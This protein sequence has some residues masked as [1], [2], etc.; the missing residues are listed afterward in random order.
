MC[1]PRTFYFPV[2]PVPWDNPVTW[3]WMVNRDVSRCSSGKAL[4]RGQTGLAG[5]Q[6]SPYTVAVL[7]PERGHL[8]RSSK[9]EVP[10]WGSQRI[11]TGGARVS[12]RTM[13]FRSTS[14]SRY[15]VTQ[16]K[17]N[18]SL[19]CLNS[20]GWEVFYYMQPNGILTE[21]RDNSQSTKESSLFQLQYNE[22]VTAS[23]K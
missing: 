19:T 6:L 20:H 18:K 3:F 12:D 23:Q 7:H 4:Q 2:P 15:L 17:E 1:P 14:I 13:D 21:L 5:T 10:C 9:M 16:G 11:K 8:L 22:N